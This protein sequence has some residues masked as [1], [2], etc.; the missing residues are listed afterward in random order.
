LS[1]GVLDFVDPDG[2]NLTDRS[3]LQVE[4]DDLFDSIDDLIP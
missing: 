2:I 4:H 1:F 3:V